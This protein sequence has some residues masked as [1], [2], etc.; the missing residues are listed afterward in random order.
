MAARMSKELEMIEDTTDIDRSKADLIDET[1]K[2][3]QIFNTQNLPTLELC[4]EQKYGPPLPIF[5]FKEESN[6]YLISKSVIKHVGDLI[7]QN[8]P[9]IWQSFPVEELL[10]KKYKNIADQLEKVDLKLSAKFMT[11]CSSIFAKE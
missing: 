10:P 3:S 5:R 6:R 11:G 8:G 2:V 4:G 1:I 9:G 7:Q